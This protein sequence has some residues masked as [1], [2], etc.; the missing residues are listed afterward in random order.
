[1]SS[2]ALI[3]ARTR[4]RGAACVGGLVL[5]TNRGLRLLEAD[6]TNPSFR[7]PYQV[8]EVWDLDYRVPGDLLAPHLEDV[9]VDRAARVGRVEDLPGFLLR[10]VEP[11]RGSPEGLFE[12][13]I[14][15]TDTG[16]GYVSR[17]T[18][19]PPISTGFWISDEPLKR[20]TEGRAVR[21]R[22]P[23]AHGVHLLSYS[24]WAAPVETIPAGTLLRVSLARWWRPEDAPGMEARCY[25][26]LSGW[27]L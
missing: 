20:V 12:G 13:L 8:G 23:L 18:G 16:S 26:Q 1:M 14:Q 4:I 22:Y 24:G 10:Q 11:W 27:Y 3:V 2:R 7:T 5:A 19:V 15:P 25:L 21:Y 6:G 17:R 9:L